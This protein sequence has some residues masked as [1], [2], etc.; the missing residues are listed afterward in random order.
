MTSYPACVLVLNQYSTSTDVHHLAMYSVIIF[1]MDEDS[2]F[3]TGFSRL[4]EHALDG[5]FLDLGLVVKINLL[6]FRVHIHYF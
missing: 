4:P 1:H 3:C 2:A 6:N 5:I